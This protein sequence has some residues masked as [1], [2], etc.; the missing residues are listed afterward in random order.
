VEAV[1]SV[2]EVDE[3]ILLAEI[4]SAQTQGVRGFRMGSLPCSSDARGLQS[5]GGALSASVPTCSTSSRSQLH[6]CVRPSRIT[7]GISHSAR[8]SCT[9][10][11][12]TASGW[13]GVAGFMAHVKNPG[14]GD[15]LSANPSFGLCA[16]LGHAHD[17]SQESGAAATA[18][19]SWGDIVELQ[20]RERAGRAAARE[21]IPADLFGENLQVRN[22]LRVC[23]ALN[24]KQRY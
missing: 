3:I 1:E 19:T 6:C 5:C 11:E 23:T 9:D 22:K 14:L 20:E 16:I 4:P 8:A 13:F 18:P 2:V 24:F 15:L 7:T 12:A 10:R 17:S 21:H